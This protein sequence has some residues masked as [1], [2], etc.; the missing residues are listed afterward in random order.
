[1]S[2]EVITGKGYKAYSD[3]WSLGICL[4]EFLCGKAPYADEEDDPY[5]IYEAILSEEL[6][7]PEFIDQSNFPA[8][9]LID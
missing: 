3:L 6:T 4:Y 1:M 7:Y 8:K 5:T 9:S 2:P